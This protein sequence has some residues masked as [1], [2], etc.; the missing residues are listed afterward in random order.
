MDIKTFDKQYK[1]LQFLLD[2]TTTEILYGGSVYSGKSYLACVYAI[3]MSITYPTTRGAICRARLTSLEKSTLQTFFQ[4]CNN[5][6]ISY[7]YNSQKHVIS[8]NNGSQIFLLDLFPL[9]AD[10]EY[11]RLGGQE[12]TW[13]IIDEAGECP[14]KA[15]QVLKTRIRYKLKENNLTP[16]MLICSN[17]TRGWLYDIFYSPYKR[18]ELPEHRQFIQALPKDNIYADEKVLEGYT[19]ENLGEA[20]YNL[21]VLGDWDYDINATNLFEFPDLQQLFYNAGVAGKKYITV[22]PAGQGNDECVITVWN[23]YQCFIIKKFNKT[24]IPQIADEV[25]QLM[26]LYSVHINNVV[27]D[28]SGLGIGVADLL[29]GCVKFFANGKVLKNENYNSLKDQM[30]YKFAQLIKDYKVG[31]TATIEDQNEIIRELQ[32]H[33]QYITDGGKSRVTPKS[34]VKQQI[35]RSPDLADAIVMRAYFEYK[36]IEGVIIG[37]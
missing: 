1:A 17:P 4:I 29:Q 21:L 34:L 25:K 13:V 14:L 32:A 33:K 3:Y 12:Y 16:K 15:Y 28:S 30:F 8:F 22:D 19:I 18:N 26:Q 6:N 5:H 27:V 2:D 20:F 36:N 10:P 24:T 35:G 7:K 31:I 23:N 37:W 9:P 11:V